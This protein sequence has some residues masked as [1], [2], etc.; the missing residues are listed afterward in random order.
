MGE[1]I[2]HS[3]SL[4]GLDKGNI[5][6]Q[7]MGGL[8]NNQIV[9]SGLDGAG[10][11]TQINMLEEYLQKCGQE[12]IYLWTRG[13]YTT[14]FNKLKSLLRKTA[15]GAIPEAGRSEA[16]EKSLSRPAVRKIWLLIAMLD[17]MRVYGLQVRWWRLM[18]KTVICDRYLADTLIDFRLNFPEDNVENSVLWKMLKLVTPEPDVTF[19]LLIP[20]EES[21]KRSTQKDEP[22]P[23]TPE[24]LEARLR[25]YTAMADEE[26]WVVL[27]G[28]NS[29][30][31]V[32][33][34][35]R[36]VLQ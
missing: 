11:S 23:D 32:W 1:S 18:G 29:I 33:G 9:F 30:E 13:G 34:Q 10:K 14:G 27:D 5:I 20:V 15:G 35:I 4:S 19:A 17:L 3:A 36:M 2:G 16:R 25:Q 22:F 7:M 24:T 12:S 31:E 26:Q 21:L 8:K 6:K 28:R